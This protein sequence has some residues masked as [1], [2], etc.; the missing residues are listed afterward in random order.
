MA[1]G[2]DLKD[3]KGGRLF[4]FGVWQVDGSPSTR[5]ILGLGGDVSDLAPDVWLLFCLGQGCERVRV[6]FTGECEPD[7][8]WLK[9]KKREQPPSSRSH[10]SRLAGEDFAGSCYV[11]DVGCPLLSS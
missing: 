7:T 10:T 9:G 4:P 3:I 5:P 1:R 6:V 8:L 2:A 11:F